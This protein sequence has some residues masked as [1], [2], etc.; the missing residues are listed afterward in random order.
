MG[1]IL[2]KGDKR[3]AAR[4][5]GDLRLRGWPTRKDKRGGTLWATKNPVGLNLRGLV[6]A[7]DYLPLPARAE[8]IRSK[9]KSKHKPRYPRTRRSGF[10]L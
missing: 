7:L 4:K 5:E 6:W 3:Q 8:R 2:A 1:G 10:I 9:V